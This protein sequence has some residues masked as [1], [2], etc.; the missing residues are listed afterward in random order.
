MKT[1]ALALLLLLLPSLAFAQVAE[2]PT[3]RLTAKTAGTR[4]IRPTSET[5]IART[6]RV[7]AEVS[8]L[9]KTE[10][11]AVLRWFVVVKAQQVNAKRELFKGGEIPVNVNSRAAAKIQID[12][13]AV[14][15]NDTTY[16]APSERSVFGYKIDGWVLRLL[17]A[18]GTELATASNT[19]EALAWLKT[20]AEWNA[21]PK[22]KP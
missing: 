12:S 3:A 8:T 1:I 10:F 4:T 9:N 14:G 20:Q 19:P 21:K 6:I 18:D 11:P 16:I 2:K 7:D 15:P 17:A 13:A 22:P 5:D